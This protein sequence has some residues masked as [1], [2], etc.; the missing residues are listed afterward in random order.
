M[1]FLGKV[2]AQTTAVGSKT[3]TKQLTS[4][5]TTIEILTCVGTRSLSLFKNCLYVLTVPICIASGVK[6][7]KFLTVDGKKELE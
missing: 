6:L 5:F 2:L 3:L 4:P 7:F 1:F